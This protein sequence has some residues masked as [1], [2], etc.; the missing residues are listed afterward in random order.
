MYKPIVFVIHNLDFKD[1]REA[2]KF[3]F[4]KRMRECRKEMTLLRIQDKNSYLAC[5]FYQ[6]M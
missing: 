2:L 6:K 3:V 4:R 5:G 1:L